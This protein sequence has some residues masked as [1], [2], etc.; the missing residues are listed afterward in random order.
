[1]GERTGYLYR[2]AGE[3]VG[4][5]YIQKDFY[6]PFAV[7]DDQ[8][9]PGILAHAETQ[10]CELGSDRIGFELP[11]INRA[12]TDYLMNRGYRLEGFFGSIMSDAPFGKFENYLLTSP[13]YFL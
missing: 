8:D 12:A 7:L 3:I 2:R 4:Y 9:F 5:G 10:A 1:M 11:L 6:G 13:P